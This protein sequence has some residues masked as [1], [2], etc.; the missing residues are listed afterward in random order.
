MIT[1]LI[2]PTRKVV[3]YPRSAIQSRAAKPPHVIN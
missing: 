3:F 2:I 1:C